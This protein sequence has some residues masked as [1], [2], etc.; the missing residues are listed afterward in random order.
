MLTQN[1]TKHLTR[2]FFHFRLFCFAHTNKNSFFFSR[3]ISVLRFFPPCLNAS[4]FLVFNPDSYECQYYC[5]LSKTGY[6][7]WVFCFICHL[8][9]YN[10]S[11][12]SLS[13]LF[14]TYIH[15]V[16]LLPSCVSAVAFNFDSLLLWTWSTIY[17]SS[18]PFY[19]MPFTKFSVGDKTSVLPENITVPEFFFCLTVLVVR[20][21]WKSVLLCEVAVI[22]SL[23]QP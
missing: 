15:V 20:D 21:H 7:G 19:G 22:N 2:T 5:Y 6:C 18:T 12:S 11:I 1:F 13:S 16:P 9:C 17:L 8:W 14:D 23:Q 10:L 3:S 4:H